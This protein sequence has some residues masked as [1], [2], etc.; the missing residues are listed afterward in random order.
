M[1]R[2]LRSLLLFCILTALPAAAPAAPAAAGSF[3]QGKG[4]SVELVSDVKTISPG[5]T[6]HLGLWLRHQPGYHTY[7]Q[8]PGLAGVPTKLVPA[9]PAGFTAGSL[10]YPPPD[11]V[12]MAAIRV[13]GYEHDVL[14]ALP[15][16]APAKLEP[17]PV[18]F[19]VEATWMCCQRTCNPGVAKLSLTLQAGPA[20]QPDPAWAPRFQALAAAQPPA[21]AG[22]TLTAVRMDKEIEFTALP[23]AGLPRPEE[24]QF[25]SLD[26]LICSH[27]IQKWKLSGEGYRTRLTLS[28]F[29]PPDTS[30]LVGVLHGKGSWLPDRSAAYAT[31]SVPIT[32]APKPAG[33]LESKAP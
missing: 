14:I 16:T 26:N 6:F 20:T 28:D 33:T 30:R 27:P 7:W 29:Q 25:F 17:G 9:L 19:P 11:K 21:L 12:K 15:V 1:I 10:I 2:F 4:L 23:P 3:F 8:N 18:S 32:D 13:H 24:P 22:W 5:Q 31:V